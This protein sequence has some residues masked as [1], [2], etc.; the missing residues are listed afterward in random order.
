MPESSHRTVSP[1]VRVCTPGR[2]SPISLLMVTYSWLVAALAAG[3]GPGTGTGVPESRLQAQH[4]NSPTAGP[5]LP[6]PRMMNWP[7]SFT[8]ADLREA[9][10]L[11]C[12][13]E[14]ANANLVESVPTDWADVRVVPLSG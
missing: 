4:Q 14:R 9:R 11:A 7:R 3:L 1:P 5:D 2:V 12:P 13:P 6:A 10:W 8:Y